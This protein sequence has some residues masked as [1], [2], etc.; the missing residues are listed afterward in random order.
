M[1]RRAARDAGL[2]LLSTPILWGATFPGGKIAL[3]RLPVLPFM[4]WSR[5]LGCLT[6]V[7]LLPLMRRAGGDERGSWR[8]VVLPGAV[9]G[10]LMF[11][12]YTMQTEG[13]ARTT[14]T[15]A[16]FITALYVVLVPLIG[17]AVFRQRTGPAGWIAV[18]VG[19]AGLTLL[20]IRGFGEVRLHVGDLLVLGGALAWASHIVAVG[21]YS[22][23][24][25]VW[26]LSLAQ[27]SAAALFHT[28]ASIPQGLRPATAAGHA[29]WPLLLL[30]GV[31]GSGVAFTIQILAQRR[32]TPSRAVI[33]LAGESLFAALFSAIWI[34]ERLSAHQW[35]GAALVL[36]A[37]AFSELRARRPASEAIEPASAV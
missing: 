5:G 36:A 17:A 25:P 33:L 31:L 23:R 18:A 32:L 13:L 19:L 20:S 10:A 9:L 26:M 28:V 15:N 37:I 34:G 29:V 11:L 24:F 7:A 30:T 35:V 4:A 14:A 27:M 21:R 12:G 1:P 3:R 2:I 22:P 6:V 16:A 8:A